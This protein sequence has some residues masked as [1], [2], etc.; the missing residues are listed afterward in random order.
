MRSWYIFWVVRAYARTLIK[1]YSRLSMQWPTIKAIVVQ[2]SFSHT[3]HACLCIYVYCNDS[4][5][6]LNHTDNA[7]L[8]IDISLQS[9]SICARCHQQNYPRNPTLSLVCQQES[10]SHISRWCGDIL[11]FCS[12]NIKVVVVG[13]KIDGPRVV[14]AEE[15]CVSNDYK[16]KWIYIYNHVT[17]PKSFGSSSSVS[18]HTRGL[19]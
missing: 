7:L 14:S 17:P 12:P 8:A 19:I 11:L 4:S 16:Y 6:Q 18:G 9:Y 15:G 1:T 10:F 2:T 5:S 13:N 3:S